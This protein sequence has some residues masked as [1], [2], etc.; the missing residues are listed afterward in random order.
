[1]YAD[2][3]QCRKCWQVK[4]VEEFSP[5]TNTRDKLASWCKGCKAKAQAESRQRN[6]EY[7]K[8]RYL[9]Q[10]DRALAMKQLSYVVKHGRMPEDV[11][12]SQLEFLRRLGKIAI[13]HTS[14]ELIRIRNGNVSRE[15]RIHEEHIRS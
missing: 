1:M 5:R 10:K 15:K 11:D 4:S 12:V 3:K 2:V 9:E 14:T 6:P 7:D 13:F 8:D